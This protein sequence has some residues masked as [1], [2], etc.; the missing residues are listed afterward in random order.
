MIIG[1]G[2]A[3]KLASV[4]VHARELT[5][6]DGREIDRSALADVAWDPEVVAWVASLGPLAPVTRSKTPRRAPL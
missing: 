1:A 2:L 4:A 6:V 5:S 3:C